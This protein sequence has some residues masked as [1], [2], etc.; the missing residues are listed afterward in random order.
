MY[1]RHQT[2]VAVPVT[3]DVNVLFASSDA[4]TIEQVHPTLSSFEFDENFDG[5]LLWNL[6][7]SISKSEINLEYIR[8]RNI[9]LKVYL[10]SAKTD[11]FL[12]LEPL[13]REL[14]KK[15]SIGEHEDVRRWAT[16]RKRKRGYLPTYPFTPAYLPYL[17][18]NERENERTMV[19]RVKERGWKKRKH[20]DGLNSI[21][22][23]TG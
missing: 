22:K 11:L 2:L 17:R 4:N 8:A 15:R 3:R 9:S 23:V 1:R 20:E 16:A 13:E 12:F 5:A 18:V 14:E 21:T 10:Q 6:I 7:G 19:R